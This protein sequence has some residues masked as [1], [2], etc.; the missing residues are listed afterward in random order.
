MLQ[1][2]EWQKRCA[3]PRDIVF[4][5]RWWLARTML[6]KVGGFGVEEGGHSM[7]I[8]FRV[9]GLSPCQSR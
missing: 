2:A 6:F 8:R 1:N 4:E 5:T 3:I 9:E 7:A